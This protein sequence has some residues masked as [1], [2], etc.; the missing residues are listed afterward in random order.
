MVGIMLDEILMNNAELTEWREN[1]KSDLS[2]VRNDVEWIKD[3]LGRMDVRQADLT[4]QVSWLRGLGSVVGIILGSVL[5]LVTR[6]VMGG[7]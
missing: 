7:E 1:L 4:K 6:I 3:N 5:A 2:V